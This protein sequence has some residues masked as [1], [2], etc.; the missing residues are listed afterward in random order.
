MTALQAETWVLGVAGQSD[1][2][3]NHHSRLWYDK[4][5]KRNRNAESRWV[6]GG[7]NQL[8]ITN[9]AFMVIPACE[10]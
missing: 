2:N 1:N 3:P 7:F 10:Q 8:S 4:W 6:H 5:P 9:H